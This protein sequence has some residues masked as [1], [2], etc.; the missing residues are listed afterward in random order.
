MSFYQV[1]LVNYSTVLKDEEVAPVAT[2][3]KVQVNR[4]LSPHYGIQADVRFFSKNTAIQPNWWLLGIF[5]TAESAGYLGYHDIAPNGMPIGK[6]FAQTDINYGD[7]WSV[8]T[9]HELL[10][11]LADPYINLVALNHVN[12]NGNNIQRLYAYEICDQCER[13]DQGY[14]IDGI[15]VSD[16]VLPRWFCGSHVPLSN[17]KFDFC[18]WIDKPLKLLAGSYISIYD[19]YLGIGWSSLTADTINTNTRNRGMV[20]SRRE[21]RTI[22]KNAWVPS[23]PSPIISI[24]P[25]GQA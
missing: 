20:G 23:N 13:S 3:L 22:P 19:I 17:E 15:T 9:S 25:S 16:F 21:R 5:D 8:T 4:D 6:V 11:M 10:E 1:A 14:D 24:N 7:K 12:V 18:G 2:A